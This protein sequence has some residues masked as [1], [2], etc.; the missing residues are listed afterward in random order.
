MRCLHF[1]TAITN[2][3]CVP[4]WVSKQCGQNNTGTSTAQSC[5]AMVTHSPMFLR[6]P[7]ERVACNDRS[8]AQ[9]WRAQAP[10]ESA[11]SMVPSPTRLPQSLEATALPQ[12]RGNAKAMPCELMLLVSSCKGRTGKRACWS[13]SQRQPL[14]PTNSRS[15]T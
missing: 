11:T 1:C 13:L 14:Y 4:W 5:L 9:A 8:P 7:A 2:E 6:S 15:I 12:A 10:R 3:Q